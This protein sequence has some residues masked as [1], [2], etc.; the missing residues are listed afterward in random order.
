MII[1][2]A[3]LNNPETL[4]AALPRRCSDH[5]EGWRVLMNAR[6]Y[7]LDR[8]DLITRTIATVDAALAMPLR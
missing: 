6:M 4:L 1:R 3:D 2:T 8:T 5:N 7:L